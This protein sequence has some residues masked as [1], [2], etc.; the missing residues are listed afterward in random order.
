MSNKK[1]KRLSWE[2]TYREMVRERE[3]W[4]DLDMSATEGL[5]KDPC[6]TWMHVVLTGAVVK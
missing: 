4:S 5:D 3:D 2:D 6:V 1:D